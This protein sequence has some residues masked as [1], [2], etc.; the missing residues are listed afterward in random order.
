MSK[1]KKVWRIITDVL[2][3][4]GVLFIVYMSVMIYQERKKLIKIDPNL[5]ESY[6]GE[7]PRYINEVNEDDIDIFKMAFQILNIR[8]HQLGL[9]GSTNARDDLDVRSAIQFNDSIEIFCSRDCF[10]IVTRFQKL[11]FF[12]FSKP[13]RCTYYTV[14]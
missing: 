7:Y 8:L 14:C 4:L 13:L 1:K 6:T 9:T 11:K 2:A 3:V 10:H 12:H 5:E